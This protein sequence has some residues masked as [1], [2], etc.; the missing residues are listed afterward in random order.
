MDRLFEDT[1][2]RPV[3]SQ[4]EMAGGNLP[5]DICQTKDELIV[6]PKQIKVKAKSAIEIGKK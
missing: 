2:M 1:F 6:K 4:Y 3:R 5:L